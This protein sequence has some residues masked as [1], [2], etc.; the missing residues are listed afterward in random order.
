MV[1]A[2]V[3]FAEA[4]T[5]VHIILQLSIGWR[6]MFS[7]LQATPSAAI[8]CR[9]YHATASNRPTQHSGAPMAM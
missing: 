6:G 7:D 8:Y 2:K 3:D 4:A 5:W 9:C 1:G